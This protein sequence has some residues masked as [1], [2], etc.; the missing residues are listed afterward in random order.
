M[1]VAIHDQHF[2]SPYTNP[3]KRLSRILGILDGSICASLPCDTAVDGRPLAE[4]VH[5]LPLLWRRNRR[6][7]QAQLRVG[8]VEGTG[9]HRRR[10]RR[11]NRAAL[12][13]AGGY[14]LEVRVV[15]LRGRRLGYGHRSAATGSVDASAEEILQLRR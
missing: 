12:H 15:H 1:V 3:K 6:G 4:G 7:R 8:L 14:E 11:P 2:S 9:G 13:E 10:R 5:G